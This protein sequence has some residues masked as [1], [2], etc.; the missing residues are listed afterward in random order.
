MRVQ[1]LWGGDT[2]VPVARVIRD[3][4]TSIKG[5]LTK[6]FQ[7]ILLESFHIRGRSY[8]EGKSLGNG[9][10]ESEQFPYRNCQ[11]GRCNLTLRHTHMLSLANHYLLF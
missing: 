8:L 2:E 7:E 9:C 10:S 1:C 6:S 4:I 3:H 11:E 5:L